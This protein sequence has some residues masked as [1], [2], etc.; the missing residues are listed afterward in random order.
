MRTLLLFSVFVSISTAAEP[1][2][3]YRGNA[4]RTGN[5]DNI[6]LPESPKILWAMKAMDQFIAAP[7][8]VGESIFVSRLGAFNQPRFDLYPLQ[9][10]GA[11]K[12]LWSKAVPYLRLA[13]VSSPAVSG[14][15]LVVGDGMH[16]DS[17][18]TLHGLAADTGRPLWQLPMTGNLI[19][20]EGTPTITS[21]RIFMGCGAAGVVCVD[22]S[23]LT[24]DGKP[25]ASADLPK[26]QE[27]RWQELQAKYEAEKKRDPDLAVP[28][29]DDDLLKPLPNIVWRKGENKWHVDAPVNVVGGRVLVCTSYLDQERVGE[30][31]IYCL[32]STTG[33]TLWTQPLKSNPW[34]G[35]AVL[36]ETVIVTG[37]SVGYYY[38]QLKGAKG[39]V[40][41]FDLK[42]GQ[43][44]WR[45]EIPG[46][47]VGCAAIADDLVVCT[48][49]D[50][51][52]R[53]FALTDGERR[54]LYDARFPI[55]APPA[56]AGGNVYVGN[57]Q[58][59]IHAI[60][61]K[62]GNGSML[63][64]L[65]QN[66]VTASPGMIYGGPTLIGGKLIVATCNLEGP[67]A[68]KP[69]CVICLGK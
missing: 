66:A 42:T 54:W 1:W 32:N 22:P 41:A 43:P 47:V 46:G 52:V 56:I 61:L 23:T 19:H 51:K 24:L 18:G 55:F 8:P 3:T 7:V 39:D 33:E 4:A 29:S 9:S 13:S 17:G 28:P 58:G 50:G 34:G 57:L 48:S 62:T 45:K 60:A 64:D 68:R 25:I 12:A 26:L 40:C 49:T 14:N 2:A 31:A 63:L 69:T 38:A 6:P 53:A 16:Q 10:A 35:A 11:P 65:G 5:N 36:G 15:L 59:A 21:S 20:L 44:K 67:F 30:R 27:S 37:S